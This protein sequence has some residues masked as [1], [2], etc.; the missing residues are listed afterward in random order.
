V[1]RHHRLL[2]LYLAQALGMPWDRV[3]EEA[4]RLEHAISPELSELIAAK[5]GDPTHDPHGDPIPDRDLVIHEGETDSLDNLPV[6]AGGRF[7]RVSDADPAM[8]R[9]LSGL[10]ICVGDELEMLDR[11]PFEGPCTVR[12]ATRTHVLGLPL[13]RAMRV[14][15]A[16]PEP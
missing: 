7:V 8:L 3:H 9:Y 2:E 6:G 13:C 10:G 12:F 1:L 11:Q 5:L 4:E 14:S 16:E 15:R